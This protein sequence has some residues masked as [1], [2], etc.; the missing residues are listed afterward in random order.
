MA[1]ASPSKRAGSARHSPGRWRLGI[2][3]KIR[4]GGRVI[5]V[6]KGRGDHGVHFSEEDLA[7]GR[8]MVLAP[9]LLSAVENIERRLNALIALI[10]DGK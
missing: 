4:A 10:G 8:L 9:A 7:N 3:G 5:A 6:L 2:D 1:Q